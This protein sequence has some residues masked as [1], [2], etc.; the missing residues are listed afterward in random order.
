MAVTQQNVKKLKGFKFFCKA[1]HDINVCWQAIYIF[2]ATFFMRVKGKKIV[3][4]IIPNILPPLA[5]WYVE[6][7]FCQRIN[8]IGAKKNETEFQ[9]LETFNQS[10]LSS[11][12]SSLMF[13]WRVKKNLIVYFTALTWPCL[14]VSDV[15]HVLCLHCKVKG[16][17]PHWFTQGYYDDSGIC[18]D[19]FGLGIVR[20]PRLHSTM[21]RLHIS[22]ENTHSR[23]FCLTSYKVHPELVCYRHM[24]VHFSAEW[25]TK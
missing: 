12:A 15:C 23:D 10:G 19:K 20:L 7:H 16:Y 24:S 9:T 1:V 3:F 2:K 17:R 25:V 22:G 8:E 21:Y 5:L 6:S 11:S 13:V 18:V 4:S 14:K